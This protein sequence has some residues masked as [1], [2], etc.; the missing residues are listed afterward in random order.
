M[1]GMSGLAASGRMIEREVFFA[2][3]PERV[4]RALADPAELGQWFNVTAEF[5]PRPGSPLRF[6]WSDGGITGE[7]V[8]VEPPQ[9][10]AFSWG[11]ER[12]TLVNFDLQGREGG[13]LL[14]LT[15]TG[16]GEGDDWDKVYS[17]NT[18][19]WDDELEHL[20]VWVERA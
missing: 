16:F 4:F 5:E 10:F 12:K 19:G 7:V 15:E 14:R 9:R 13:T 20:R 2:A 3:T 11:T 1:I 8:A 18:R 17:D 6:T